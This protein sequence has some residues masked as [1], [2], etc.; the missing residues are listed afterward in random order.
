MKAHRAVVGAEVQLVAYLFHLLGVYEELFISRA[1]Y[2]FYVCAVLVQPFGLRIDG[3]SAHASGDK[4][5]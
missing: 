5:K 3:S 2:H 1:N 4:D